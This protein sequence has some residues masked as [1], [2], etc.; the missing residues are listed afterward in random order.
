[1]DRRV[2][3]KKWRRALPLV[4]GG[5]LLAG[6]AGAWIL[7]APGGGAKA[8][9]RKEIEI[10]EARRAPFHDYVPVRG[11]VTPAQSVFVDSFEGGQVAALPVADGALVEA[12]TVIAV[13]SNPQLER[14]VRAREA[15]VMGRMSDVQGQLLNLQR[16]RADR[17][18]E[19]ETARYERLRAERN[20]Q[21]RKGL[22]D[23]GYVS[24]LELSTVQA[25]ARFR[26]EQTEALESAIGRESGLAQRQSEEMLRTLEQLRGNLAAVRGSLDALNIRA[27]ASG[28]LTA[29]TLQPGQTVKA[30]DRIGQVD[31]EGA[32]KLTALIDEFHLSRI[33]LGQ[34]ASA[35]LDGKAYQATVSRILP[36]V[37]EGRFRIELEF[38][39][40]A[41]P[42]LRR[43]QTLDLEITMGD[44]RPALVL[45]NAPF[46][47]ATGGSWV[48]VLD[49]GGGRAERRAIRIGRRNPNDIE[50]LSGLRPGERVVTSSYDSFAK[51]NRLILR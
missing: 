48:F 8:V 35:R 19:L 3:R 14:E 31:T 21:V 41:P 16:S 20:L 38:K 33:S 10:S 5:G 47:E 4:L 25:E 24:D 7:L 13:L 6:V 37:N 12:G 46:V 23:K 22:H 42:A 27:P 50:V 32:Y 15:E 2:P 34:T 28:R 1:M 44:T 9:D 29:F 39:G 49:K 11:E 30:G 17:Q 45:P 40:A 51:S 18:R 26:K 43:G 36:Q